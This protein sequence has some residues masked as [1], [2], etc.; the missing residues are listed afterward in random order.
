MKDNTNI[1]RLVAPPDGALE[2]DGGRKFWKELIRE[3]EW[4]NPQAGF[5]LRVDAERLGQ[6]QERFDAMAAAGI[7]VPL[8]WG[9]SYDPRDNAGFVEA[10]E[11]RRDKP[12]AA[13]LWGLL[14]VPDDADAE[15]LGRTVRSVSVSIH[16][17]YIDGT[18]RAWGEVIEHVALTNYPVVVEQEG[19]IHADDDREGRS[20]V[21]LERT[22]TGGETPPATADENDAEPETPDAKRSRRLMQLE[23]ERADR[24]IDDAMRLGKFTRPVARA[25]R[26]LLN[27]GL[28]ERYAL[29]HADAEAGPPMHPGEAERLARD[30]IAHTPPGAAVAL[31]E[32]TRTFPV[33]DPA[34][35]G[36]TAERAE[37]LAR[38]NRTLAKV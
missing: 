30:I 24:E 20:A 10:V 37:R 33:P 7:R 36:M 21:T 17:D 29:G 19:F 6:W 28:A 5:T 26:R 3:G 9:H 13:A 27:A 16:P 2:L 4:T 38:E 8:P 31:G 12:G 18:G 1:Y 35:R 15:K 23:R 25:L 32:H 11:L 22:P 34:D 14:H